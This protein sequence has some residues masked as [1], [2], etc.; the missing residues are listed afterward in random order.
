MKN[1][2]LTFVESLMLVA[3]AGMGTGILTIPYAAAKIGLYGTLLALGIAYV[4]SMITYLFIADLTLHSKD[5]TQL[6]GILKQHLFRGRFEKV[7]TYT[8]FVVFVIILLQNLITYILCATN[9]ISELFHIPEDASKIL[10]YLLAL[11]VLMFGIKGVGIGEKIAVP[12]IA[13]AIFLLIG[14]SAFSVKNDVSQTFGDP[15]I[16][17]AV[18]GLFMF[19]FSAIFSVVQV[20]NN[21]EKQKDT[22]KALIGGLTIN[23]L[24]TFVFTVV[25]LTGSQEVTEVAI[26]GLTETIGIPWVKIL[27][28]VFVLLAMFTSYWS[29]GMAFAD[30]L[31]DEFRME[32]R[33]AVLIGTLPATILA[34]ILP[35]SILDYAQIGAGALSVVVGFIILPAY[36]NAVKKEEQNLLL[37]QYSKSKVIIGLIGFSTLLMAISSFIP[38]E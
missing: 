4:A 14:L 10:F 6:L 3:G 33:K 5:S 9:I 22:K 37:G 38:I 30:V 31:S 19:A 23:A 28:S 21:I 18:F 15:G 2:K 24:L 36:Y 11:C 13:G 17:T 29:G 34:I 8:F 26:L 20:T 1:K 7:L 32:K 16:V 35:L 27:S 25:T 12:L